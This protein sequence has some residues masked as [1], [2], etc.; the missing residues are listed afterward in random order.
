MSKRDRQRSVL[1]AEDSFIEDA[2]VTNVSE[3]TQLRCTFNA[4]Y[5]SFLK[6]GLEIEA[7]ANEF[8]PDVRLVTNAFDAINASNED[9]L[10][11]LQTQQWQTPSPL[12]LLC[13]ARWL[14]LLNLRSAR[15][16]APEIF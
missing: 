15:F 8:V 4:S 11:K 2:A 5:L 13:P 1:N 3:E 10:M 14:T 9:Q 12:L 7:I 16:S 6:V